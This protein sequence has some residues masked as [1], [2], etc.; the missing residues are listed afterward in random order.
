MQVKRRVT[1]TAG[2]APFRLRGGDAVHLCCTDN[3]R[4]TLPPGATACL[5]ALRGQQGLCTS[6]HGNGA[7]RGL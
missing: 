2:A 5:T 4:S 3:G 6:P 1:E 7:A